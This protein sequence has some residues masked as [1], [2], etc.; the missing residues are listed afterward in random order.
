MLAAI[1]RNMPPF[2]RT[3]WVA[4]D[5]GSVVG[6]MLVTQSGER[7]YVAL[8][9]ERNDVVAAMLHCLEPGK[10]YPVSVQDH[11]Q[12]ALLHCAPGL[13]QKPGQIALT[14]RLE[15]LRDFSLDGDF[16]RL[17]P[18]DKSVAAAFPER[19]SAEPPLAIFLDWA[20]AKP[21]A[22]AAFGL[23]SG[24]HLVGYVTWIQQVDNVREVSMI[25]VRSDKQC[26][27]LGRAMLTRCTRDMLA[28]GCLPLY[29]PHSTNHASHKTA[30]AAGYHEIYR[31][32]SFDGEIRTTEA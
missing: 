5:A 1:E 26:K 23:V 3:I 20:A 4:E 13:T 16:R 14:A 6:V 2:P 8:Q 17:T 19:S 31:T 24:G 7:C 18:E 12:D 9:T 25:R 32:C 21:D 29:Q 30:L 22:L 27:G 11:L 10:N 15:D 28:A